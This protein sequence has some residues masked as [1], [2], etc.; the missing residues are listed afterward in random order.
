MPNKYLQNMIRLLNQVLLHDDVLNNLL[1][2]LVVKFV[3]LLSAS[4][5]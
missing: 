5:G 3:V 1:S 2:Y 4:L